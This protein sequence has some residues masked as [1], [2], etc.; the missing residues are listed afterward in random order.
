MK[1]PDGCRQGDVKNEVSLAG[2]FMNVT[3]GLKGIES[4][5]PDLVFLDVQIHD[6]TGFDL[7][8]RLE[9]K[10]FEVIF[11][12]AFERFAVQAFKYIAL[13]Y[14]LK[15]VDPEDLNAALKKVRLPE[16]AI[17]FNEQ[18]NTLLYNIKTVNRQ[19]HRICVPVLNGMVFLNL[20]DIIRLK[21]DSNYTEF[22]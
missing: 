4:L 14:L 8:S 7:L 3:D 15:P 9:Q 22:F 10:D 11:T 20:S 2:H 1:N 12:T 19:H 16:K 18:V 13:D 6:E 5:Q 21:S 17:R